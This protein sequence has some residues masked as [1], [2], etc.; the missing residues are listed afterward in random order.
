M[1]LSQVC[2]TE[3][4]M[5]RMKGLLGTKNLNQRNGLLIHPCNSVHTFFMKYDIDVIYL[6]KNNVIK[7]IVPHL[8][9]WKFSLCF[10]SKTTLELA[11]GVAEVLNL[12]IGQKLTWHND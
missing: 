4:A 8:K 5:E 9:P 1:L 12:K 7:K 2:L 6:D 10:I 11:A 3:T